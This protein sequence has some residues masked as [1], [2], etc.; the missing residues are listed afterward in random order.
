MDFR[1]INTATIFCDESMS[2]IRFAVSPHSLA[3]LFGL[4][5]AILSTE[6]YRYPEIIGAGTLKTCV[7]YPIGS[8]AI[9]LS[10]IISVLGLTVLALALRRNVSSSM[11]FHPACMI[12]AAV[13][14]TFGYFGKFD[15]GCN[16]CLNTRFD[17]F[18]ELSQFCGFFL[19]AGWAKHLYDND[20]SQSTTPVAGS[21]LIIGIIQFLISFLQPFA[22]ALLCST[23]APLSSVL[24]MLHRYFPTK[25]DAVPT[26]PVSI[27]KESAAKLE[28]AETPSMSKGGKRS[29]CEQKAIL[30]IISFLCYGVLCFFLSGNWTPIQNVKPEPNIAQM[31]NALGTFASSI[32]LLLLIKILPEP[33]P[34]ELSKML[35]FLFLVIA[36][37]LAA[38][39]PRYAL[40]P[41]LTPLLDATHKIILFAAW[42]IP[43]NTASRRTALF[44]GLLAT[45]QTGSM[46]ASSFLG[47]AEA[48]FFPFLI[49]LGI[50]A[51]DLT[52]STIHRSEVPDKDRAALPN[53]DQK[54]PLD[55][56]MEAYQ[57]I[58]FTVYL[59]DLF[60]LTRREFEVVSY[61][62]Q[63]YSVLEIANT[64]VISQETAKTHRRNI[65][66]KAKVSSQQELVEKIDS[67]RENEFQ[68]FLQNLGDDKT[69]CR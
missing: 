33:F 55:N 15:A 53:D 12:I 21:F 9:E 20:G 6:A 2:K 14:V 45:Y 37:F 8:V 43:L 18:S 30:L 40:V 65:F 26:L 62:V 69:R 28:E 4:A 3:A 47:A 38:F 32:T 17:L 31:L 44:V 56:R 1:G 11:L 61:L 29:S 52:L 34:S 50:L 10:A 16:A 58:L 64:L 42:V 66:Q 35:V 67:I 7:I 25:N 36:M 46:I 57:Q 49:C 22:A 24:F 41:F 13:F 68:A 63:D 54:G 5:A 39:S 23:A 19:I 60:Q 27:S 59:S 48:Q 51:I